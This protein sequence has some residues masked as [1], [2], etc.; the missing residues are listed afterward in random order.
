MFPRNHQTSIPICAVEDENIVFNHNV[1]FYEN[2]SKH[3][4]I[5]DFVII[6]MFPCIL[7]KK[8]TI[9]CWRGNWT[10][11]SASWTMFFAKITYFFLNNNTKKYLLG[12]FCLYGRLKEAHCAERLWLYRVARKYWIKILSFQPIT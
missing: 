8:Y 2:H 7:T 4:Y 12:K 11:C 5:A 1:N 3:V 6:E 10:R 9:I